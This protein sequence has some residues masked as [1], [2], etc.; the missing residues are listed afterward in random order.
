MAKIEAS[1]PIS[2]LEKKIIAGGGSPLG[3]AKPKALIDINGE[4][5]VIK[6]FNNEPIDTPLIEHATM[7]LATRAAITV[8]ET[9]V[10]RLAGAN[11][12]AVRRFDREQGRRIHSISAGTAIRA[13]TPS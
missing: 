9:Q 10:I 12:L 3:G 11:A 4:Q 2:A 7:T 5:W 13:A 1:E 6:F 8:T